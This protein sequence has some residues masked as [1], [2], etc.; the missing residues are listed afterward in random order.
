MQ[1]PQ[2]VTGF[3]QPPG[4]EAYRAPQPNPTGPQRQVRGPKISAWLP[5]CDRLPGRD[6]E[7]FS[8]LADKFATQGYQTINQLTGTRMS[9]KNLLDWLGIGKGTADL[10]I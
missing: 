3:P 2:A 6:G 1:W 9:V 8:A 5:Y 10:I 4:S 7:D